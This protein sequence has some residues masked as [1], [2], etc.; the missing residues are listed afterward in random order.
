MTTPSILTEVKN[1]NDNHKSE[2]NVGLEVSLEV[3][4]ELRSCDEADRGNEE[5]KSKAFEQRKS[6]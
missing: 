4:E 3:T 5:D 1:R 6:A 2:K